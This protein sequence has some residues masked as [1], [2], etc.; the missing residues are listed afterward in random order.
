MLVCNNFL[1]VYTICVNCLCQS[2]G[3][4]RK[5]QKMLDKIVRTKVGLELRSKES[6]KKPFS[7]LI[8]NSNLSVRKGQAGLR[9]EGKVCGSKAS[10][11]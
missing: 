8:R 6:V 11:H 5:I 1:E 4:G 10:S 2:L 9:G 3:E 7:G